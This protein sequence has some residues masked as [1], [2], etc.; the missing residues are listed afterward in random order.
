M[1]IWLTREQ[2]DKGLRSVRLRGEMIFIG[3]NFK[4]E[5]LALYSVGYRPT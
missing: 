2:V 5:R 4:P 1:K 3:L